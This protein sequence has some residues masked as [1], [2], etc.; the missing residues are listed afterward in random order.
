MSTKYKF[1]D[2]LDYVHNN[3]VEAEFVAKAEEWK[4]NSAIDYYRGKRLL[5]IIKLDTL[6]V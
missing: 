2:K 1:D 3:S 5:E 6:I 4:Y